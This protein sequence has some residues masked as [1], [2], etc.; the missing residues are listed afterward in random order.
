[1]P[2]FQTEERVVP[3]LHAPTGVV[4]GITRVRRIA[5][6]RGGWRVGMEQH[7]PTA[8]VTRRDGSSE[9]TSIRSSPVTNPVLM[10]VG[11]PLAAHMAKKLL[12]RRLGG[13][14]WTRP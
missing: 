10:L 12:T 6:G 8:V 14:R 7:E 1:M 4:E 3:L 2:L 11:I 9:R 5:F 13:I